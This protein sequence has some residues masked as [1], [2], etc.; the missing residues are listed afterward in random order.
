[1]LARAGPAVSSLGWAGLSALK[2]VTVGGTLQGEAQA[3][4]CVPASSISGCGCQDGWL[5]AMMTD[6]CL[7]GSSGSVPLGQSRGGKHLLVSTLTLKA[8][9]RLETKINL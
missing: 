5:G 2:G 3:L 7:A 9:P 4:P 1:M 6:D 8:K